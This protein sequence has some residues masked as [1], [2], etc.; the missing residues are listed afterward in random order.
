VAFSFIGAALWLV[1]AYR[2]WFAE[3][4]YG[5]DIWASSNYPVSFAARTAYELFLY[6]L[7]GPFILVQ[8]VLLSFLISHPFRFLC[9]RNGLRFRR[10]SMDGV[11]GF[12]VFGNQSFRNV[13][14]LLPISIVLATYAVFLP[15]TNVLILGSAAYVLAFPSLFLA[16][17]LFAHRAMKDVKRREL[18]LLGESYSEY[19][20]EYKDRLGGTTEDPNEVL[21]RH[22]SLQK[23]DSLYD[24]VRSRPT[25][26]FRRELVGTVVSLALS[27]ATGLSILIGR[28]L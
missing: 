18:E 8:V 24:E 11:G 16:Q 22:D 14:I 3:S 6:V 7:L 15:I 1:G 17:L 26:P 20:E 21:V 4:A 25:W 23:A 2:H 10:F 12:S 27:I 19:Y 13:L 28:S 9:R 5:F